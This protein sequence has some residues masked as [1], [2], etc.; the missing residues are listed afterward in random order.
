MQPDH[1]QDIEQCPHPKTFPC[2]PVQSIPFPDLT[3]TRGN[4]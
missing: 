4:A 3:P 1:N 2:A